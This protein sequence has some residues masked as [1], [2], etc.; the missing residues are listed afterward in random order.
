M[1]R[2]KDFEYL[3]VPNVLI[4]SSLNYLKLVGKIVT[5]NEKVMDMNNNPITE[6][7]SKFKLPVYSVGKLQNK[8]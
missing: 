4:E 7:E 8:K 1:N 6:R 3:Y 2:V 5:Y